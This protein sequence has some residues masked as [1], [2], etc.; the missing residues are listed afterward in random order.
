MADPDRA[1]LVAA[2][3]VLIDQVTALRAENSEYLRRMTL[4]IGL[5]VMVGIEHDAARPQV[6][7]AIDLLGGR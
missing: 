3:E 2:A 6:S 5:L 4:A 1:K 7:V